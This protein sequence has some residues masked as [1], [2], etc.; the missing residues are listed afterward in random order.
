MK[1]ENKANEVREALGLTPTQAGQLLFGYR[2]K[3]AYDTWIQWE[4]GAKNMSRPTERYFSLI[5]FLV[6]MRD[7]KKPG[8]E[9]AL[10]LFLE[11]NKSIN[12]EVD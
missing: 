6:V 11:I 3:Q 8:A 5:L 1:H 12:K 10:D 2:P 4:S 7:L 9:K